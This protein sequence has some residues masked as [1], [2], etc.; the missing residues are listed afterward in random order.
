MLLHDGR[1]VHWDDGCWCRWAVAQGAV[2]PDRV[3]VTPPLLDE[4][5]SFTERVEYLAVKEFI[6]K[7]RIEAFA[8]TIFPG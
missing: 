7:P 5:P 2:W 1:L 4:D 8:I 3:V 6:P